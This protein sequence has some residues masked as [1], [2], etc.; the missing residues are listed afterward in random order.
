[1]TIVAWYQTA[2]IT[3][4][5]LLVV[6]V[7]VAII[8]AVC[9]WKLWN[10]KVR[11]DVTSDVSHK[12]VYV[13]RFSFLNGSTSIYFRLWLKQLFCY[14]GIFKCRLYMNIIQRKGSF[15]L[16]YFIYFQPEKDTEKETPVILP[17]T[18]TTTSFIVNNTSKSPKRFNK[19]VCTKNPETKTK[20][21]QPQFKEIYM[22]MKC[23][24]LLRSQNQELMSRII[25]MFVAVLQIPWKQTTCRSYNC[26]LKYQKEPTRFQ[27]LMLLVKQ[28]NDAKGDHRLRLKETE[29]HVKKLWTP[30]SIWQA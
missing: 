4:I 7:I 2:F 11:K 15:G 13:L 20:I 19:N 14:I 9:F 12:R 22:L 10:K 27:H 26:H 16:S 3:V 21:P 8:L 25:K 29:G 30:L 5:A 17:A 28:R 6:V 23:W 24:R 18:K 1:L